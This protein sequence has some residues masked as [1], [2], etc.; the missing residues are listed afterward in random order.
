MNLVEVA[1]RTKEVTG[2]V[3]HLVMQMLQVMQ[4]LTL[5]NTMPLVAGLWSFSGLFRVEQPPYSYLLQNIWP[6]DRLDIG[7]DGSCQLDSCWHWILELYRRIDDF[8]E[9]TAELAGRAR[10][11]R[12]NIKEREGEREQMNERDTSKEGEGHKKQKDGEYRKLKIGSHILVT[13]TRPEC[14]FSPWPMA[15]LVTEKKEQNASLTRV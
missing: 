5:L 1:S 9:W 4:R 14:K 2:D 8:G 3:D 15:W 12:M 11:N 13:G 6:V 10:G 7:F